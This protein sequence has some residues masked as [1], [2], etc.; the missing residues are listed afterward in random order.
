MNYLRKM[1]E[2]GHSL[3]TSQA[4]I[5]ERSIEDDLPSFFFT[6][7]F[8]LS[9]EARQL[10]ELNLDYAGITEVEIYEVIKNRIKSKRG[11]LL[12]FPIMHFLGYFYRSAAYLHGVSSSTLYEKVPPKFLVDNYQTLHSLPIEEAIKEAFEVNNLKVK[13]KLERFFEIFPNL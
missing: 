4:R 1:D 9:Y 6:K 7:S 12:P 2:I 11:Q 8:M 5:F 13:T 10:D 3:A